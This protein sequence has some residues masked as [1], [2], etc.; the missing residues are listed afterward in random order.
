MQWSKKEMSSATDISDSTLA[1]WEHGTSPRNMGEVVKR[2]AEATGCDPNWLMWGSAQ[3]FRI[4]KNSRGL[5]NVVD[6]PAD[7]LSDAADR[8]CDAVI[9][10]MPLFP[11]P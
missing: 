11:R 3:G 10:P 9:V 2:I 7:R 4:G 5:L 6:F 8:G 1:Q